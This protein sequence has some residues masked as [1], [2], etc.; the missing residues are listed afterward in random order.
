MSLIKKYSIP[1]A[2]NGVALGVNL[3][4]ETIESIDG[5][6]EGFEE[7]KEIVVASEASSGQP[8][9]A[10]ENNKSTLAD[11]TTAINNNASAL[12]RSE[13]QTISITTKTYIKTT[14]AAITNESQ[15]GNLKY[16]Q[17]GFRS[18]DPYIGKTMHIYVNIDKIIEVLD[19]NIDGNGDVLLQNFLS[20]LMGAIGSA[21][22]SINNFDL[23]YD[24][25]TNRFSII[26]TAVFPLKYKNTNNVAKFNINL[27]KDSNSGGGSFVTNFGLKSEVFGQISNAIA[28]GAQA[29]GNTL[30]SNSTPISNFNEGLTDRIVTKKE[31]SNVEADP[32]KGFYQ[33]KEAYT[34]YEQ[35]KIKVTSESQVETE[36]ITQTDIDLYK[37]F[38]VDLMKYDIGV[39]TNTNNIP[40]TGFIPLNLQL[41]MDGLSGIRQYQTFDIDETLLPSE[42]NDKLK[43]ITTTVTHKIDTK[44]WETTVS[45][46]GVPKNNKDPKPVD[47]NIPKL[48]IKTETKKTVEISGNQANVRAKYGEPGDN[49]NI[50]SWTPPYTF[51]YSAIR[52]TN[53]NAQ[54]LKTL[55]LH[56]DVVSQFTNAFTEVLNTYGLE[57]IQKLGLNTT[58]GTYVVRANRND[59]SKYSLHS[60]GIAIDMLAGENPNKGRT[61][62]TT[63]PAT[64][65][66]SEYT[67]FVNILEKHGLYSLGKYKDKDWMHF[68]TWPLNQK[69]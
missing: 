26:D 48:E 18:S 53:G 4:E 2:E 19:N 12:A 28:I 22:C 68:Q 25:S 8:L 54:V 41:T 65:S 66:T 3:V 27:L 6:P 29:N 23:D 58:S 62:K 63:P 10:I 57:Q 20:Q 45:S 13:G 40:G 69:E 61:S 36:S 1:I 17:K 38:L 31:N 64:F 34:K 30:S 50:V 9:Y 56:K 15:A 67:K 37:S 32:N 16:V 51:Y 33:W 47:Q 42:Y 43:F 49:S 59:A 44:G 5:P 35:F 39:Y 55:K 11:A 52:V 24:E 60:W 46:L 14:Q 7:W 21:L